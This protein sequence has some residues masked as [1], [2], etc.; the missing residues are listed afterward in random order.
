MENPRGEPSSGTLVEFGGWMGNS[1]Y[2]LRAVAGTFYDATR[3]NATDAKVLWSSPERYGFGSRQRNLAQQLTP[4]HTNYS[5]VRILTDASPDLIFNDYVRTFSGV[6]AGDQATAVV[7]NGAV[8]AVG[9]R[10]TFTLS[11]PIAVL[12]GPFA[13]ETVRFDPE[14]RT[15]AVKTVTE[16]HPLDPLPGHPLEGWRYWRVR[17][18]GPGE[19]L[20]E[21]GAVDRP[22]LGPATI[23]WPVTTMANYANFFLFKSMQTVIWTQYLDHIV[24][25]LNAITTGPQYLRN[26][27]WDDPV[28]NQTY[29][30]THVC[31]APP[32]PQGFCQ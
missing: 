31:G 24:D 29:I 17:Q 12:Q 5:A 3:W 20:V 32:T 13:V 23:L 15:I 22:A 6:N 10:V 30:M 9:Q 8:S 27:A 21:T 14:N 4:F 2:G 18:V 1:D 11:V 19:V 25:E 7:P 28:F 16:G 26:G